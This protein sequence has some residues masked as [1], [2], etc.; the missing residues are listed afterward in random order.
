MRITSILIVF[1]S[2]LSSPIS[3]A[4]GMWLPFLTQQ[5][6]YL[7][8]SRMGFKLKPGEIYN[9]STPSLK[10]AVFIFG[11]GCTSELVSSKGLLFTN[12]H[13]GY[14]FI[15]QHSSIQ[16]NYLKDGFFAP[17]FN[18]ELPCQGLSASR[19]VRMTLVTREVNTY[20]DKPAETPAEIKANIAEI[21]RDAT[22]GTHYVAEVKPLFYG[23]LYL[24]VVKE[25]FND[26][27]LV[28]APPSYIGKYGYDADN[29]MWPRHTGD[30]AVFRVYANPNNNPANYSPEN[31]P[32]TP[33][34]HLKSSLKGIQEDDLTFV[35]G[36]P[37]NTEQY[38][39][40][41]AVRLLMNQ[42][43]PAR[44]AMRAA[45]LKAINS[46]MA[47]SEEVNIQY[48]AKQSRI[49]NY[50]KKWIGENRGLR[51]L[52]AQLKKGTEEANIRNNEN[53]N[54][55]KQ[56]LQ[57]LDNE[58]YEKGK[59]ALLANEYYREL[60]ISGPE[61]IR[62]AYTVASIIQNLKN[63]EN[64]NKNIETLERFKAGIDG[65]YKNFNPLVEQ[66]IFRQI[67][68]VFLNGT[69][70]K[71]L[72][73]NLYSQ[74]HKL[75]IEGLILKVYA[76]SNFLRAESLKLALNAKGNALFKL[77]KDPIIVL[78]NELFNIY[79][80]KISPELEELEFVKQNLMKVWVSRLNPLINGSYYPDANGTLRFTFGRVKGYAPADGILYHWQTLSN[81]ILQKYKE[82]DPD[83]HLDP[84]F[85]QLIKNADWKEYFSG[86]ELPIAFLA[87]NHTTGGNS[88]SPVLNE[89]GELIGINFDRTWESTM[90]D[91]MYDPDRCRNVSVDIRY[92]AFIIDK[93]MGGKR[94]INEMDWAH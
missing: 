4:E 81:G 94:L 80:Q 90:S 50:W 83:F 44:I 34:K 25:V 70:K 67:I 91:I 19:I 59:D 54:I 17:N 14:S 68:P 69:P 37:G 66:D 7:A 13:C 49:A 28:L 92:V 40:Q 21:I 62:Y 78:A 72:P 89:N 85:V 71:F 31:I 87:S 76:K 82:N 15:Q 39:P 16:K 47:N 61:L 52:Q 86:N 73:E 3:A 75:G 27:R 46:A 23:N 77:E 8:L 58:V 20:G 53:N 43:N 32:Y 5:P 11:G 55:H 51:K 2:I 12:H 33:I 45:A 6:S 60:F 42:T 41:S 1:L 35:Y 9:D 48:A 74:F 18:D 29:W 36:F 56:I 57:A 88:G 22:A 64:N 38:L 26:V 10:D 24:L 79:N 84:T 63:K 65:F 30:F 93:L